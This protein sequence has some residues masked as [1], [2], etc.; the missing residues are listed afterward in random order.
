MLTNRALLAIEF[1]SIFYIPSSA[2]KHN[3]AVTM[4]NT[5]TTL[6]SAHPQSSK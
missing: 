3:N 6:V 2:I 1:Y 5:A 4:E